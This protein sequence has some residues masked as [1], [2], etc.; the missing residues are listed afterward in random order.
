[1]QTSISW[2]A[3]H[4]TNKEI[5]PPAVEPRDPM[6]FLSLSKVAQPLTRHKEQP[7][8]SGG[9]VAVLLGNAISYSYSIIAVQLTPDN[10]KG[11]HFLFLINPT[12]NFR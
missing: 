12:M 3:T 10:F 9:G 5:P 4:P 8:K 6:Q 7:T 11:T 1:M 2:N